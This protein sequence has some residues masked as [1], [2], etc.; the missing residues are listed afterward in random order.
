MIHEEIKKLL[1]KYYISYDDKKWKKFNNDDDI[2]NDFYKIW[3][4]EHGGYYTKNDMKTF[5]PP[6]YLPYYNIDFIYIP[7]IASNDIKFQKK[8]IKILNNILLDNDRKHIKLDFRNNGGG[9]PEVMIAG[10]LPLFNMSKRKVLTFITTKSKRIFDIIKINNCITC[11][12]NN[13]ASICGTTLK[14]N[15]IEKISIYMN[16]YTISSGEQSIIALLSLSDI[17]KIELIGNNSGGYTTC[18]KY[19]ELSN[20]CGIEIPVGYMTDIHLNIYKKGIIK[21]VK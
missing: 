7:E 6:K 8:Y 14:M 12:S 15:K 9:K 5:N 10:L 18:N 13:K 4:N 19:I 17:V 2:K 11:I 16:K 1:K 21:K 3:K 20:G